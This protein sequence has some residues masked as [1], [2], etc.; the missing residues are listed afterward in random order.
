M[1]GKELR[2]ARERAG[3]TQEQLAFKAGVDRSYISQLDLKQ[4][5]PSIFFAEPR[6]RARYVESL[7][8]TLGLS[9]SRWFFHQHL[10]TWQIAS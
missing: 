7:H 2:A 3:M 9:A 8:P 5:N 1:V 6:A 4:A 10:S